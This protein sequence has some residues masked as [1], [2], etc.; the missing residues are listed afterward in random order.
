MQAIHPLGPAPNHRLRKFSDG[1][2]PVDAAL[3][4]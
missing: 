3:T 1:L 4:I 2:R